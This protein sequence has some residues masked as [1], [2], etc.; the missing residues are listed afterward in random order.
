MTLTDC[1]AVRVNRPRYLLSRNLTIRNA[2]NNVNFARFNWTFGI[3]FSCS[4]H[5]RE[6]G[7][8]Y[9]V[10]NADEHFSQD[11]LLWRQ[12]LSVRPVPR[13]DDDWHCVEQESLLR[14]P[15]KQDCLRQFP[16]KQHS[17]HTN[18]H[19]HTSWNTFKATKKATGFWYNRYLNATDQFFAA[20]MWRISTI[21]CIVFAGTGHNFL[22]LILILWLLYCACRRRTRGGSSRRR[23]SQRRTTYPSAL[24]ASLMRVSVD[25]RWPSPLTSPGGRTSFV[26]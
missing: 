25:H 24:T 8:V 17:S 3:V 22:W 18:A 2:S 7:H 1:L 19:A 14:G 12:I 16:G 5:G 21:N 26:R 6:H 23:R 20:K 11:V 15:Q 4:V 13:R 10:K 9:D